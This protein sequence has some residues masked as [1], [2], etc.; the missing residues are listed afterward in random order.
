MADTAADDRSAVD[1]ALRAYATAF[2]RGDAAAAA[3]WC[4]TPFV[5]VTAGGVALAAS[6]GEVERAYAA[7][8]DALRQRGFSHTEYK[9]LRVGMLGPALAVASGWAVRYADRDTE[10]ERIGATYLLRKVEGEWRIVVL[11]AH[12]PEAVA[13][14]IGQVVPAMMRDA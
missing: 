5:W 6:V 8:L 13:Q 14:G 11:T 3:R 12:P 2:A 1:C 7:A 4:Q 9:E 10:L